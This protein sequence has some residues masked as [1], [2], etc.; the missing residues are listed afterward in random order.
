M[1]SAIS[2][3]PPRGEGVVWA[4]GG[5]FVVPPLIQRPPAPLPPA[6]FPRVGDDVVE[7]EVVCAAALNTS[8]TVPLPHCKLHRSRDH[9]VLLELRLAGIALGGRLWINFQAELED[10]P[11]A[12]FLVPP[13]HQSEDP[14]ED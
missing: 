12:G 14:V 9:S 6:N 8:P 1:F 7:V 4:E 13:M 5:V 2:E 11:A 10:T 3:G